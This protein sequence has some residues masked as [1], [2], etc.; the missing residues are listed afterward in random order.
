MEQRYCK[1]EVIRELGRGSQ[2]V[3]YLVKLN[4]DGTS[5]KQLRRVSEAIWTLGRHDGS[6]TK[7]FRRS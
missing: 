4:R 1:W 6:S 3:V 7:M 2:G 5:A